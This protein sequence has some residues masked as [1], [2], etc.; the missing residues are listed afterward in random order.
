MKKRLF[1]L[2]SV[3]L[4]AMLLAAPAMAQPTGP[5]VSAAPQLVGGAAVLAP[6]YFA[7]DAGAN[8]SATVTFNAD[9]ERFSAIVAN[10]N[11]TNNGPPV[12]GPWTFDTLNV[13]ATGAPAR[14]NLQTNGFR[15]DSG[16]D[17]VNPG[18]GVDFN[19]ILT[20]NTVRISSNN[21]D[22]YGV[23]LINRDPANPAVTGS[24]MGAASRV[25]IGTI[26]VSTSDARVGTSVT[27]FVAGGLAD[28]VL[29]AGG[30]QV[31]LGEVLVNS[32]WNGA[33]VHIGAGGTGLNSL[34]AVDSVNVRAASRATGVLVEGNAAGLV[35]AGDVRVSSTGWGA[36]G[37]HFL[38]NA[39]QVRLGGDIVATT[40]AAGFDAFGVNAGGNANIRLE[41]NV[42]ISASAAAV[43]NGNAFGIFSGA[44]NVDLDVRGFDLAINTAANLA[45][46]VAIKDDIHAFAGNVNITGSG[47]SVTGQ[48]VWAGGDVNIRANGAG[49]NAALNPNGLGNSV[50]VKLD[51]M[52]AQ[53]HEWLPL[54]APGTLWGGI[55]AGGDI[56]VTA[57]R[58]GFVRLD[59]VD[60]Q[61]FAA[62]GFITVAATN[63]SRIEMVTDSLSA[64]NVRFNA[65]ATSSAEIALNMANVAPLANGGFITGNVNLITYGEQPTPPV[66]ALGA[67][68]A[69]AVYRAVGNITEDPTLVNRAIFTGYRFGVDAAG[70]RNGTIEYSRLKYAN[71]KGEFLA[72]GVIHNRYTGYNMVRDRFISGGARYGSGFFGQC[73]PCAP[74]GTMACDPCDAA[75]CNPCDDVAC[76]PCDPCG[77]GFGG[78][79]GGGFFSGDN[80]RQSWVNYVG[81]GD[82]YGDWDIVSNGVQA[83]TDLIRT[84]NTQFGLLFGYEGA[85][86]ERHN[87]FTNGFIDS[88][89]TYVGFYAARVLRGGADVRFVYNH[90]WQD[91]D[92]TRDWFDGNLFTSSFSGRT[93]EINMEIGKRFHDGAFSIRPFVAL[94]FYLSHLGRAVETQVGVG[95]DLPLTYSQMNTTQIFVRPGFEARLQGRRAAINTGFSYAGDLRNEA[96]QNRVRAVD[97]AG[98]QFNALYRGAKLGSHLIN[99]NVGGELQVTK[100]ASVFGGYDLQAIV[101]RD[102]GIM[103]V[104]HVGG[105]WRW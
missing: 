77:N 57:D 86:A 73:D 104:G 54:W 92:M 14:V 12:G 10:E 99:F 56:N 48:S 46:G 38:G 2:P 1:I 88:E 65:D 40:S 70:N 101:D 7:T 83:G 43:G 91:F 94:D 5:G 9:G 45:G 79:K 26:D 19:G 67:V 4:G 71:L 82:T 72:A 6:V 75:A 21:G 33:G 63:N 32:A 59:T 74:C 66:P 81:R 49:N 78:R 39:D 96:Y 69:W 51:G 42:T 34:L 105:A 41:D 64:N 55:W 35:Q 20:G 60:S 30:A 84:R 85:N 58:G 61:A 17:G 27:G 102:G 37:L 97:A 8:K 53:G 44:G 50:S 100:C 80:R 62:A 22:V 89:D 23:N 28:G 36:V 52:P 87:H 76:N 16:W 18:S 25:N 24:I 47:G 15:W 11:S 98:N 68:P 31:R 29:P 103:H 93:D 90:G 13:T 3:L 95:R